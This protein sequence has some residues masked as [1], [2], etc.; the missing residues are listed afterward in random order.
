VIV[1]LLLSFVAAALFPRAADVA[2]WLVTLVF[3]LPFFTFGGGTLAWAVSVLVCH[4]IPW[5]AAVGFIGLPMGVAVSWN[6]LG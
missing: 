1:F 6:I 2:A 4:P 5:T 3:I